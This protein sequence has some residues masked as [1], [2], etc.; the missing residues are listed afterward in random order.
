LGQVRLGEWSLCF[1]GAADPSWVHMRASVREQP[2]VAVEL[3]TRTADHPAPRVWRRTGFNPKPGTVLTGAFVAEKSVLFLMHTLQNPDLPNVN[4]PPLPRL[5]APGL[6]ESLRYGSGFANT[7]RKRATDALRQRAGRS[8]EYWQLATGTGD[9][10]GLQPGQ[11]VEIARSDFVMADPF[12]FEHQDQMWLF[13]EAMHPDSDAAWIA[14]GRLEGDHLVD[15]CIALKRDY[16]LSFPF[17]F[18]DAGDIYMMPETQQSR[19]L[20]IWRA[21]DFPIGW[22][23]HATAFEDQFPADSTL[24]KDARGRWWLFTNLSDHH[25]FQDHSNALYLFSL[26]GPDLKDIVAHPA[27][28][29]VIGSGQ[30]R[31]AGAI[32]S[33]NGRLYRPSQNNSFGTYGYGLNLM[34]IT[35]LDETGY[36]EHLVRA[37]TPADRAGSTGL[38]HLTV[39]NDRFVLDFSR[40]GARA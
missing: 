4:D 24:F 14:A 29:V 12:L 21:T 19:R 5:A 1:A 27:N 38:H 9:V 33:Q 39:C 35:R 34:E 3:L 22:T 25:A 15:T 23:L 8:P 7:A 30:A 31:N 40:R 6:T 26:S 28:P 37:W 13:F 36:D 11:A 17:V 18:R 20:E 32:I 2:L 10:T 16:H